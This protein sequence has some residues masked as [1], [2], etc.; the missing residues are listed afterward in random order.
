MKRLKGWL[1]II[2]GISLMVSRAITG[3][4]TNLLPF[5]TNGETYLNQ[6]CIHGGCV[7]FY[8]YS[9]P[10]IIAGTCLLIIGIIELKEAKK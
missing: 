3:F 6:L 5:A 1:F 2:A 8:N 9:I 10:I 4:R 7:T